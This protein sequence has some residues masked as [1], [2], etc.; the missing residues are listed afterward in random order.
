[1]CLLA[2]HLLQ[3][4]SS[5]CLLPGNKLLILCFNI[6]SCMAATVSFSRPLASRICSIFPQ[7]MESK[8]LAKST[9]SIVASRFFARTSPTIR[10]I[11]K[12]C[13]VVDLF[14]RKPFWFFLSMFSILGSMRFCCRTLYILASM[15][16][17]V[18][19]R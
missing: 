1:M 9:N 6:V 10:R 13:D 5:L 15:D 17:R 18:L 3:C 11:V 12:I 16:V 8:A 4:R 7:C 14:A 2:V 19:T